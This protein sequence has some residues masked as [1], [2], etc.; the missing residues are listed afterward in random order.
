M[1]RTHHADTCVDETRGDT[2]AGHSEA[3][4]CEGGKHLLGRVGID[5]QDMLN[6]S[7]KAACDTFHN[8]IEVGEHLR[9]QFAYC[10]LPPFLTIEC[11]LSKCINP[12]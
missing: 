1:S 5:V 10:R 8:S 3:E 11:A 12:R 7:L 4:L 9:Y 6:T 2:H